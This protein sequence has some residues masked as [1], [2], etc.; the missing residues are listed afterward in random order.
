VAKT[1]WAPFTHDNAGYSYAGT[2]LKQ[3]WARLHKGDCEPFPKDEKVAQA[4]RLYHAG[5]FEQAAAL[6]LSVGPGGHNAANKATTI[7]ATYLETDLAT[8]LRLYQEVAQRC[9]EVRAATPQDVNAHYLYAYALGRY[10]QG[11][12]VAKAL[13]QGLGGKVKE[14]LETTLSLEPGHAEAHTAYGTYQA[15]VINKVGAIVAGLTYGAKKGSALE[16]FEEALR[17]TPESA[18]AHIEYANGLLLLFGNQK[19]D[20]A[21]RLYTKAASMKPVEAMECL[22]VAL[23]KSELE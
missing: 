13:T 19:L 23:A 18:I 15:E 11:I 21:T 2:T 22:D 9:E 16:H 3:N 12:S 17:L 14:A 8:R 7:Y 1:K 6:G 5:E 4:W 20:E 10:S